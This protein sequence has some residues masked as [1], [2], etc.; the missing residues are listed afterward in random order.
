MLSDLQGSERKLLHQCRGS[1]GIE[2]VTLATAASFHYPIWVQSSKPFRFSANLSAGQQM[3]I[4]SACVLPGNQSQDSGVITSVLPNP[5][6]YSTRALWRNN[7]THKSKGHGLVPSGWQTLTLWC[8]QNL[9]RHYTIWPTIHL[10][11]PCNV[12]LMCIRGINN[13]TWQQTTNHRFTWQQTANHVAIQQSS[14]WD[15]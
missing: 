4:L 6:G 9:K 12:D 14:W 13:R 11:L 2:P 15:L 3:N 10:C 1:L 7:N 5:I 8:L